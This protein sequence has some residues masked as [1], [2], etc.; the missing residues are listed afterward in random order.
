MK[1]GGARHLARALERI[2]KYRDP[3]VIYRWMYPRR[4]SGS[5]TDGIIPTS[6]IKDVLMAARNEGIFISPE[7]LHPPKESNERP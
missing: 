1:F 6:A 4:G 2:G 5:G 3:S 7:E